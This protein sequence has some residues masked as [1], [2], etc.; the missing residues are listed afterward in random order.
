MREKITQF[1]RKKSG[2]NEDRRVSL[3]WRRQRE[4]GVGWVL[5]DS[6]GQVDSCAVRCAVANRSEGLKI[7]EPEG[8]AAGAWCCDAVT[9]LLAD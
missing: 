7:I 8:N 6:G 9:M 3:C 4:I 1:C 5:R 2:V